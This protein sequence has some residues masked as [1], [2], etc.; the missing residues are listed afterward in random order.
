V[1]HVQKKRKIVSYI[2]KYLLSRIRAPFFIL[3]ESDMFTFVF[4][5]EIC[6]LLQTQSLTVLE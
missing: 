5:T 2:M 6:M 4:G 1:S 3:E